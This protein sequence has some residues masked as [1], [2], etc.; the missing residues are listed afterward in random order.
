MSV[1]SFDRL[2]RPSPIAS[3]L[4]EENTCLPRIRRDR[5]AESAEVHGQT[6]VRL[7]LS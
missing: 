7:T 4:A 5:F 3:A 2:D 6:T 1:I